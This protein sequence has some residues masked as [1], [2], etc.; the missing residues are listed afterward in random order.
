MPSLS[1]TFADQPLGRKVALPAVVGMAALLVSG[2]VSVACLDRATHAS[3][4]LRVANEMTRA[5]VLA[6]MHHDAVR[7]DVL[8]VALDPGAAESGLAEL[9]EHG[10]A[11]TQGVASLAAASVPGPVADAATRVRPEVDRYAAAAER[12]AAATAAGTATAAQREEFEAGF[13][14][15]ETLLPEVADAIAAESASAQAAVA[16]ARSTS[17]TLVG[18]TTAGAVVAVV[19]LLALVIRSIVGA[20]RRVDATCTALAALDLT[21]TSGLDRRDE[22]GRMSQA[23][24]RAAATLRQ[25]LGTVAVGAGELTAA[26][27]RLGAVS[28]EQSR[29]AGETAER[30]VVAPGA[31][32]AVDAGVQG[33]MSGAEQMETAVAE[34]AGSASTAARV[35]EGALG[36]ADEVTRS[37]VELAGGTAQISEVVELITSIAEQTNLLAL[38]ATIEA[39]RAGEAGKG[40]AVVAA[41][42]KDLAQETAR[43]T[44]EITRRITALQRSGATAEASVGRIREIIGEVTEHSQ[45]IA[46]AVEEQA[47]STREITR[48]IGTAARSSAEVAAVV[49]RVSEIAGTTTEGARL[50]DDA[51]RTVQQVAATLSTTVSRFRY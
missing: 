9:R 36:V 48:A 17:L 4:R 11:L 14:A 25:A 26:S 2:G 35:A 18:L 40:F 34:I 27:T 22:L 29:T 49:A 50:G 44:D 13:S 32:G 43:S 28:T 3:D 51:A 12:Y 15:V 47:E 39:A 33:A 38:N 31:V 30:A 23:L 1:R 46:T 5:A 45:V 16:R 7:S 24:D 41:E 21:A 8:A 37:I 6:D 19:V 10:D 20:V 42:V